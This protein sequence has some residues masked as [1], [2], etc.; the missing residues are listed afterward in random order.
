MLWHVY[1]N[2]QK[3]LFL[4]LA[5]DHLLRGASSRR[6]KVSRV[7]LKSVHSA[8][9]KRWC[10]AH[11]GLQVSQYVFPSAEVLSLHKNQ[12]SIL[13][14]FIFNDL[15]IEAR[16]LKDRGC[17]MQSPHALESHEGYFKEN[18]PQDLEI[19]ESFILARFWFSFSLEVKLTL[20]TILEHSS[21][22][23]AL[24]LKPSTSHSLVPA[25]VQGVMSIVPIVR[26]PLSPWDLKTGWFFNLCFLNHTDVVVLPYFFM[27]QWCI[28]NWLPQS[29]LLFVLPEG[30]RKSLAASK[31]I[32]PFRTTYF[33]S[34]W[35]ERK[36]YT[37]SSDDSFSQ[38][39]WYLL[40]CP[41]GFCGSGLQGCN[42]A[43]TR[44]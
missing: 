34:L 32:I 7:L 43:F 5:F 1:M 44:F 40:G 20:S 26:S 36:G 42:L 6:G 9:A 37:F 17:L 25:F 4:F 24:F 41:S 10:S 13:L 33:S 15:A 23:A 12:S 21:A 35:L 22:L 30:P 31:S 14:F 29:Y 28:W 38:E 18:L 11:T 19:L 16:D 8:K 2:P 27:S 39:C 3:R